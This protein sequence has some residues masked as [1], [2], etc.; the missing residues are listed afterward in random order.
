MAIDPR[1]HLLL[2]VGPTACGK[3][4]F[5]VDAAEARARLTGEPL[6]EILNCDSVQF[7]EGVDIGAAKPTREQLARV[8]HHLVGH[9]PLGSAYTAGDFRR[10]ALKVIEDRGTKGLTRFLPVGGSGFYVQAL[11]KGMYEVPE[12][13]ESIKSELSRDLE[14]QG[15]PALHTELARRDPESAQKIQPQDRYRVLRALEILRSSPGGGTL[16][17]IRAQFEKSRGPSPFRVSK[18]GLF[19]PRDV[20]RRRIEERTRR[21]IQEGLIEEVESLRAKGLGAWSPMQSVGY[22]ETQEFLDG[23]ISRDELEPLIVTS[24]MQLAKRQMTWFKR[25]TSIHWF[26]TEQGLSAPLAQA[27]R[28]FEL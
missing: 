20:L 14:A 12:V 8:P 23:K 26:D 10:D 2:V 4:D 15:L 24:T 22:K 3:T 9:V 7:F 19:R 13:P 6:P 21:M 17:E 18:I 1:T 25:D 16:S 28:E 27:A 11:E 5:A